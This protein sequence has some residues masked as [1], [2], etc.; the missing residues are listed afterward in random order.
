MG[1]LSDSDFLRTLMYWDDLPM[2]CILLAILL[3]GI[4]IS[5]KTGVLEFRKRTVILIT[6][7]GVVVLVLSVSLLAI[8]KYES[9]KERKQA[10]ILHL[11][12][13]QNAAFGAGDYVKYYVPY[14]FIN[15]PRL[16]CALH[17]YEQYSGLHL[18]ITNIQEYLS[19]EYSEDGELMVEHIPEDIQKYIDW[20]YDSHGHVLGYGEDMVDAYIRDVE[21]YYVAN[22]AEDNI[23]PSLRHTTLTEIEEIVRAYEA[24]DEIDYS[25]FLLPFD[26]EYPEV[27]NASDLYSQEPI[28]AAE[29][30]VGNSIE[31]GVYRNNPL[32]WNVIGVEDDR[33][34]LLL[35]DVLRTEDG[36]PDEMLYNNEPVRTTW[37]ECSLR[38]WLNGEFLENAFGEDNEAVAQ[39]LNTN[40]DH[41]SAEGGEDTC[42]RIFLLSAED[43]RHYQVNRDTI[44]L[45]DSSVNNYFLRDIGF[46]NEQTI[47]IWNV[48]GDISSDDL[49]PRIDYLYLQEP[50]CVRPA[51][52]VYIDSP[53]NCP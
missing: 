35:S 6:V 14:S 38:S 51:M 31:F 44:F 13:C 36:V 17:R 29:F 43:I 27:E 7:I 46:S 34:L 8:G 50:S 9:Y 41:G 18:D 26:Y 52:W 25:V 48:V 28:P 30:Y 5:N 40:E 2:F 49:S 23:Y 1:I 15:E 4:L 53:E 19:R 12:V 10:H 24:D 3:V 32:I 33:A 37:A 21:E 42:D 47:V 11:Y 16:Y 39:V 20:Y 45:A 22:Q